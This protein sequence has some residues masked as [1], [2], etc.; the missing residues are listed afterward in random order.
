MSGVEQK[1]LRLEG[2]L[3]CVSDEYFGHDKE[4][5][6]YSKYPRKPLEISKARRDKL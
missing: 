3:R 2:Q 5:G 4:F 6:F 1:G